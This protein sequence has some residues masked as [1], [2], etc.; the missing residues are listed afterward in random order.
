[1]ADEKAK[2]V[3]DATGP[4]S[5]PASA[6]PVK[7]EQPAPEAPT[8]E[9]AEAPAQEEKAPQDK[10]ADAPKEQKAASVS[11]FN[12]SEIMAEK[13]ATERAVAQQ[14]V[15]ALEKAASPAPSKEAGACLLYTSDAADE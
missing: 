8:P 15:K 3:T 10:A 2:I 13:K 4:G 11:V 9:K 5:G 14:E 12:F 6:Q 7:Q 1:M